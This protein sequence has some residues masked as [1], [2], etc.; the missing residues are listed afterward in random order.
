MGIQG[1]DEEARSPAPG[2]EPDRV[3]LVEERKSVGQRADPGEPGQ[4]PL[5]PVSPRRARPTAP[6]S[7]VD[8]L[9]HPQEE[10]DQKCGRH[11]PIV[12]GDA[13][14]AGEL[15]QEEH[16]RQE[17][18]Q[19]PTPREH[20]DEQSDGGRAQ[21]EGETCLRRPA[22]RRNGTTPAL[23]VFPER[24]GAPLL[25]EELELVVN[26]ADTEQRGEQLEAEIACERERG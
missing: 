7:A 8:P 20:G 10:D 12:A 22:N 3:Q 17:T 24:P 25:H 13:I 4:R 26:R 9:P 19:L 16:R 1:G 11:Q 18:E 6:R 5:V 15:R 14:R 2:R 23:H 21:M